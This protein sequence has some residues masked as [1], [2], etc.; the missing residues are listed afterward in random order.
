MKRILAIVIAA[1]LLSALAAGAIPAAAEDPG[2][3]ADYCLWTLDETGT[4]LTVSGKGK[5]NY[6]YK[7]KNSYR[8]TTH[9]YSVT[10][11]VIE[12]GITEVQLLATFLKLTSVVI[13]DSVTSIGDYAFGSCSAL[14]DIVI[15]SGVTSIGDGAFQGCSSLPELT[16]PNGV[17]NIGAAVFRGCTA[18]KSVTVPSSV[19]AIGEEAFIGCT[20]LKSVTIPDGVKSIES[21]TFNG[22]LGLTELTIPSSVTSIGDGAFRNCENLK[23][24]TIPESVTSIGNLVFNGCAAVTIHCP[25]QSTIQAY[26]QEKRIPVEI[27]HT[28]AGG[29]CSRCGLTDGS[30][31]KTPAVNSGA[32]PD[33]KTDAGAGSDTPEQVSDILKDAVT[34]SAPEIAV[35]DS[36]VSAD[37]TVSPDEPHT[38]TGRWVLY[39][40]P[41][42][43]ALGTGAA[44][45]VFRIKRKGK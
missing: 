29:R 11:I 45:V 4:V 6:D 36:D 13:P 9:D 40:V 30:V 38:R 24:V 21:D 41:V 19:K 43:I 2:D 18:L 22:C 35:K 12:Y 10:T 14:V 27:T 33:S 20:A 15:P 34:D 23:T 17:T 42:V 28:F 3:T 8:Y 26:A 31:S 16:I 39:G 37:D 32:Q 5:M 7:Q 44:V 1:M 25:C